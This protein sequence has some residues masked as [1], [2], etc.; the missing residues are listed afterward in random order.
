M[1][2]IKT[3]DVTKGTIKTL[4]RAASS[5]HHIKED[6]VRTKP[7]EIYANRDENPESYAQGRIEQYTGDSTLY[8]ARAG[9]EL[10]HHSTMKNG[11]YYDENTEIIQHFDGSSYL[12]ADSNSN[13]ESEIRRA[14]KE[15]GIKNIRIR[16][17]RNRMADAEVIRNNDRPELEGRQLRGKL[18]RETEQ[19]QRKR[20][21]YLKKHSGIIRKDELI[22]RRKKEYTIRKLNSGTTR[23]NGLWHVGSGRNIRKHAKAAERISRILRELA[24]SSK[25]LIASLAG[26]GTAAIVIIVIMIFCGASFSLLGDD[27]GD[28]FDFPLFDP[29]S[30]DSAIV[31]VAESQLGNVGGEKYWRWYGFTS[32]VHWCACFVSWC[33][34]QCGYIDAEVI[35]KFS[36]VGHGAEW[37]KERHRWAGRDYSPRPGDIIFFDFEPDGTLD[38]VGIVELCDGKTVTTIE[39]NSR[40]AC[41]RLTYVAGSGSIAGYGVPKYAS[42]MAGDK[43]CIWAD[44]IARDDSYHYVHWDQGDRMTQEC[45]VCND[46]P[47]GKYKGWNCIGFAFACWRHGAG[48]N[49]KCNCGVINTGEW[50]RLL[51]FGS[52]KEASSYASDRIGVPCIVIRNNGDPIPLG[53]LRRGD[54]VT[55]YTGDTSYHTLFYEGNCKYSDCTSVGDNI[56]SHNVMTADLQSEAKVAIRYLR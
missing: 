54:I 26:G 40:N 12:S 5:M 25:A 10:I 17:E 46:Y 13:R 33:G 19:I 37:F 34:D 38:H 41:R 39:G 21:K 55:L 28:W 48:I 1:A 22:Q 2:D 30:G 9:D 27:N 50:D 32:H 3:R 8:V 18:K 35:P 4:D 45:P 42:D 51:S 49:C 31:Q 44:Q 16:Q 6:I 23:K 53:M 24:E 43:A 7:Y 56:T 29:A 20:A 15:Q 36:I 47:D 14:L 11:G 52:D